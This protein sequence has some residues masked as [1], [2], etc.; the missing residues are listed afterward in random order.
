MTTT[1]TKYNTKPLCWPKAPVFLSFGSLLTLHSNLQTPLPSPFCPFILLHSQFERN[2]WR[3]SLELIITESRLTKSLICNCDMSLILI[4]SSCLCADSNTR[5]VWNLSWW[6]VTAKETFNRKISLFTSKLDI[7]LF[8]TTK[9]T[10]SLVSI[11]N[12]YV[13]NLIPS[14]KSVEDRLVSLGV[15][16]SNHWSSGRGFDPRHFHKF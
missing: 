6:T 7:V 2:T 1:L 10:S 13:Q 4:W 8:I 16:T 12:C 15:S 3:S 9:S 11:L 5:R 14:G